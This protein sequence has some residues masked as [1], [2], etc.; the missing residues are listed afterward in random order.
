[1]SMRRLPMEKTSNTR[2]LGGYPVSKQK[3]TRYK[4][5]IRSDNVSNCNEDDI[6]F[7]KDYGVQ[8]VIDLRNTSEL[9]KSR[10]IFAHV[11][12]IQ[13]F[14][15]PLTE[16][17]DFDSDE[18]VSTLQLDALYIEIIQNHKG[19]CKLFQLLAETKDGTI[20][21]HCTAGKDRTGVTSCI[22]L[23]LAGVCQEDI[24]ADY[25][26]S[27]TYIYPMLHKLQ[28]DYA[29]MLAHICKSDPEW[30]ITAYDYVIEHYG[31]AKGYLLEIGLDE[32]EIESLIVK[33]V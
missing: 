29:E 25:Q 3:I 26:V 19:M 31:S 6:L 24:I 16:C 12:G 32:Q 14:H 20:L 10:N 7:L 18:S 1:M 13:Y 4:S 9:N 33:M 11:D 17:H 8:T 5:F 27:F 28:L 2:E 22:L 21:Y 15:I 30:M 23:M